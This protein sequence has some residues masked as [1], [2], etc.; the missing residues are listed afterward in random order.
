M[1]VKQEIE[2]KKIKYGYVPNSLFNKSYYHDK[3]E[4]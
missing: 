3:G 2:R 4:L 1:K